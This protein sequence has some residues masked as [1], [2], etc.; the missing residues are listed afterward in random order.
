MSRTTRT[1]TRPFA[2]RRPR[3]ALAAA[4]ASLLA[5]V[6]TTTVTTETAHAATW[7]PIAGAAKDIGVGV[8]SSTAV[9][10]IGFFDSHV[11]RRNGTAWD[12]AGETG[13]RIAVDWAGNAWVVKADGSIRVW[14]PATGWGPWPGSARDI[15]IGGNG[16]IWATGT[17]G[18]VYQ[19]TGSSWTWRGGALANRIDVA[20]DGVPWVTQ[21]T[22]SLF[23]RSG[24]TGW[25]P[26]SAGST[27]GTRDVGAGS[28]G[29]VWKTST[30]GTDGAVFRRS[31]SGIGTSWVDESGIGQSI[32]VDN[33]G[34]A[35]VTQSN[36]AIWKQN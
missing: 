23:R 18:A 15:A 29:S 21:T 6:V 7:T 28:S 3:L 31:G 9:W 35:W 11:Y 22:G 26:V 14:T 25:D 13:E 5:S 1:L 20:S 32:D 19:W 12:A 4:T 8:G 33:A 10:A 24:I 17:D 16:S 34:K 30:V 36:G 2:R 27:G